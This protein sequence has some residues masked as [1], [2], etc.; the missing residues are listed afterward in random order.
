[1]DQRQALGMEFGTK[2]SKNII[3]ARNENAIIAT[4]TPKK[5]AATKALLDSIAVNIENMPTMD[6]LLEKAEQSKPRPK[7]NLS[8]KRPEEVYPVDSLIPADVMRQLRVD[9]WIEGAATKEGVTTTSR[10]VSRRIASTLRI[11]DDIKCKVLKYM[12]MVIEW[13]GKAKSTRNGRLAPR[14][15]EIEQLGHPKQLMNGIAKRFLSQDK[16]VPIFFS[17]YT[18][19]D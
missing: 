4:T 5:T 14:P 16:Y 19:M 13:F 11:N 7:A 9:D 15:F 1:M 12:L 10:Y 6:D 2:K 8:A 18:M 17:L 3:K